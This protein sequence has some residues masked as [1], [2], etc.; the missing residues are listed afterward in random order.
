M[1]IQYTH[2]A[3][4][5]SCWSRLFL[6]ASVDSKSTT[7]V[8]V[9]I[10]TNQLCVRI[11]CTIILQFIA[12]EY[13]YIKPNR[14]KPSQTKS[15]ILLD[16]D[17]QGK[18]AMQLQCATIHRHYN[19]QS[20]SQNDDDHNDEKPK[21]LC[22]HSIDLNFDRNSICNYDWV[23]TTHFDLLEHFHQYWLLIS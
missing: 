1:V 2:D 18:C 9:F 14:A 19:M 22:S 11:R 6:H 15:R 12:I 17:N 3:I 16:F 4:L 5:S 8:P 13:E 7:Y 10:V 21:A 20:T 23:T